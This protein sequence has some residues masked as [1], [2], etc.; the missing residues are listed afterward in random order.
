M[1][2]DS[3]QNSFLYVW[4]SSRMWVSIWIGYS[5]EDVGRATWLEGLSM[6]CLNITAESRLVNIFIKILR[7]CSIKNIGQV[8][9][10]W[11]EN[12]CFLEIKKITLL[13]HIFGICD[14]ER[15]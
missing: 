9:D 3:T 1:S 6:G 12:V 10:S 13:F 4:A 15:Q 5:V 8:S 11:P 7:V 14:K 2:C